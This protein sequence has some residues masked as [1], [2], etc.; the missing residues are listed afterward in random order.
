MSRKNVVES[1]RNAFSGDWPL[2]DIEAQD[3]LN[4][5]CNL[6][7]ITQALEGTNLRYH[8][9]ASGARISIESADDLASRYR[10]SLASFT[11]VVA[12]VAF[13]SGGSH[14]R[15]GA[16][17]DDTLR[18]VIWR[19][20]CVSHIG[21]LAN[22]YLQPDEQIEWARDILR[23]VNGLDPETAS[24]VTD[25]RSGRFSGEI[26]VTEPRVSDPDEP[27]VCQADV[28]GGADVC[29]RVTD[30]FQRGAPLRDV[31]DSIRK[32]DWRFEVVGSRGVVSGL[33]VRQLSRLT[34]DFDGLLA[35]VN[36][37]SANFEPHAVDERDR[38]ALACIRASDYRRQI[39]RFLLPDD[40][41][42]R[43]IEEVLRQHGVSWDGA[44]NV[45]VIDPAVVECHEGGELGVGC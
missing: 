8:L 29:K 27:S 39:F 3:Q 23:A 14:L 9:S 11:G 31:A 5:G 34:A 36:E 28:S 2:G 22:L 6:T 17:L 21:S 30:S 20:Q 10:S 42:P 25:T 4:A 16:V 40:K 19:M 37:F 24:R 7:K 13:N 38:L 45:E 12:D 1:I 33:R 43:L 15:G 35:K 18:N 26:K 41:S 32:L 44:M